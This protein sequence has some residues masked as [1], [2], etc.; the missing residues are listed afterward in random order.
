MLLALGGGD[1]TTCGNTSSADGETTTSSM[2]QLTEVVMNAVTVVAKVYIRGG[3]NS[4]AAL[5]C[6]RVYR[7]ETYAV[8]ER[9]LQTD[10]GISFGS[11]RKISMRNT[12]T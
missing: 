7:L 4:C 2:D 9:T 3:Y 10:Q 5:E 12:F 1:T 6:V 8:F 11:T